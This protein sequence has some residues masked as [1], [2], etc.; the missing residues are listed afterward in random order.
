MIHCARGIVCAHVSAGIF[1]DV[2][3]YGS[4]FTDIE[5]AAAVKN[6]VMVAA[7]PIAALGRC[8]QV[9][10]IC[11]LVHGAGGIVD[12]DVS[13]YVLKRVLVEVGIIEQ[14][15]KRHIATDRLPNRLA[16]IVDGV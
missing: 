6:L 14:S 1:E 2:V 13:C 8:I 9:Q 15:R 11:L 5:E 16:G 12:A 7:V 4:F 3:F 10:R